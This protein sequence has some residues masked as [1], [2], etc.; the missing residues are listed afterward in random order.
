MATVD[1]DLGKQILTVTFWIPLT[2]QISRCWLALL[3]QFSD[4]SKKSLSAYLIFSLSAFFL[5]LRM[6][7]TPPRSFTCQDKTWSLVIFFNCCWADRWDIVSQCSFN[8]HFFNY[9]WWTSFHI[10]KGMFKIT[11]WIFLFLLVGL[12]S[13]HI[14]HWL[15]TFL[16]LSNESSYANYYFQ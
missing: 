15:I 1:L 13:S 6:S 9:T 10:F 7:M 5:V 12:S 4:G 16:P 14:D 3:F 2:L 8:L 11:F